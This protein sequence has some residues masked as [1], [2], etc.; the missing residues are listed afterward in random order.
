MSDFTRQTPR[1][2]EVYLDHVGWYVRNMEEAAAAFRRLGFV[3]TP[4]TAHRVPDSAGGP[5]RQLGSANRCA[6]LF[7]GY[8]EILVALE[9]RETAFTGEH[10]DALS[11]YSG[12]HLIAFSVSDVKASQARLEAEGFRPARGAGDTRAT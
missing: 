5:A 10:R 11:R 4:F 1:A 8:L 2:G 6:M 9:G 12:V 3:L 7:R